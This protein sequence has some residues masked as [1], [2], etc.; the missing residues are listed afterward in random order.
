MP[1]YP[2]REKS[3]AEPEVGAEREKQSAGRAGVGAHGERA[4][5]AAAPRGEQSQ[6]HGAGVRAP[7][8]TNWLAEITG[9][10]SL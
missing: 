9:F 10:L 6:G 8:P 1:G 7:I 2:G 3:T 4:R 5:L